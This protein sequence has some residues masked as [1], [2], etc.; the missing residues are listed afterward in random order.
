VVNHQALEGLGSVRADLL[1]QDLHEVVV[2]FVLE[3]ARAVASSAGEPAA[4]NLGAV[5]LEAGDAF[6]VGDLLLAVLGA[7]NL[8]IDL[9]RDS[10]SLELAALALGLDGEA[11]ARCL[12]DV[13]GALG[14]HVLGGDH[15]V[16]LLLVSADLGAT[17]KVLEVNQVAHVSRRFLAWLLVAA[18]C[19]AI[20]AGLVV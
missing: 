5:T 16:E 10:F 2:E 14:A 18:N 15:R 17:S 11:T 8:A 4:V 6:F 7:E 12:T 9:L 19:D 20:G 1:L 13:L 3:G